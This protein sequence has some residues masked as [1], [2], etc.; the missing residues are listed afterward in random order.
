M[1]STARLS[2][3]QPDMESQGR[4][5]SFGTRISCV[6]DYTKHVALRFTYEQFPQLS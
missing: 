5:D 3:S 4:K 2:E 1:L 6:G